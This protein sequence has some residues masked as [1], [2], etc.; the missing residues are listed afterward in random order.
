MVGQHL[1]SRRRQVVRGRPAPR[2]APRDH[3]RRG[4]R[5]PTVRAAGG[6]GRGPL[7]PGGV[8]GTRGP[9]AIAPAGAGDGRGRGLRPRRARA[10][11]KEQTW[12]SN[13]ISPNSARA[14][15][16][17]DEWAERAECP[18][19]AEQG[20]AGRSRVQATRVQPLA[21][22]RPTTWTRDRARVACARSA[23]SR[24]ARRRAAGT[25]TRTGARCLWTGCCHTC[26]A[27]RPRRT[28]G[29]PRAGRA[30][31]GC[32]AIAPAGHASTDGGVVVPLG[33]S[34]RFRQRKLRI[35]KVQESQPAGG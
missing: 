17:R 34:Q 10:H 15:V 7:A 24:L 32:P 29:E 1:S 8:R 35:P 12:T 23:T 20:F 27:P 26:R 19:R 31:G 6:A 13:A 18:P 9:W 3:R 4:G 28:P 30:V 11:V 5:P 22:L 21:R 2:R 14:P 25:C 33:G 16:G